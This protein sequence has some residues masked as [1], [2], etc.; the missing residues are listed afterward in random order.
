MVGSL[1]CVLSLLFP[2]DFRRFFFLC[3]WAQ[4]WTAPRRT[5]ASV[6]GD[7]GGEGCCAVSEISGLGTQLPSSCVVVWTHVTMAP[8]DPPSTATSPPPPRRR[9]F[10]EI[11]PITAPPSPT[12]NFPDFFH[13]WLP[14]AYK[15]FPRFFPSNASRW[16]T[17]G[18]WGVVSASA[19]RMC[20]SSLFFPSPP[21]CPS[22]PPLPL[23]PDLGLGRVVL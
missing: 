2:T 9:E 8:P 13:H 18:L 15:S 6:G 14:S 23:T 20:P 19:R 22:P 21:F 1:V 17:P 10:S 4:K 3:G 11:F 5:F 12:G 7:T 16:R